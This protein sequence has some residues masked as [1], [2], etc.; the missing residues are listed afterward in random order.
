MHIPMNA[1]CLIRKPKLHASCR[2]W[3]IKQ[4]CQAVYIELRHVS[5]GLY[6]V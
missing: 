4:S 5:Q 6:I 2:V 1:P 3:Y